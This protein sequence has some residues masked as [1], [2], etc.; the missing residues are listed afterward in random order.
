MHERQRHLNRPKNKYNL[1][2]LAILTS[3]IYRS[4]FNLPICN[5]STSSSTPGHYQFTM[6]PQTILFIAIAIIAITIG[7]YVRTQQHQEPTNLAL[8]K[9]IL[10]PQTKDIGE[11]N[12]I[13]HNGTAFTKQRLLGKWSIVFFGFTNCPDICP[14]TLQTLSKVKNS[15]E[16][17]AINSSTAWSPYQVIMVSVDPERDNVDK[18]KSYVPWFDKEFIGLTGDLEYTK[19]FAKNLGILFYKS[20]QQSETVYE[21]DHGASLILINPNGEYAGAITAP[22]LIDEISADLLVM[23][24]RFV[25]TTAAQKS[26]AEQANGGS[27]ANTHD[28]QELQISNAWIRSAPPGV[29]SMAAY[30]SLTNL[31]DKE[32]IISDI[33]S[34][35][36]AMS[37]IH[38]TVIE[39]G[40]ASMNHLDELAIAAGETVNL[41]PLEKHVMLMR[42]SQP[43]NK[44]RMSRLVLIDKQGTRYPVLIEVRDPQ[45]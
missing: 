26:H 12:F 25:D 42:P 20:K 11:I 30:M 33:E 7:M 8:K 29:S 4:T 5:L 37:M 19:Q 43:L 24:N 21:V 23:S 15:L 3:I 10:L 14:T 40:V 2:H 9:I 35:D 6:K 18:L 1:N 31:S 34:P 45:N 38:D 22:H 32:I 39:D 13:D 36:F 28:I 44:G 17:I 16:S 27:L 41:A